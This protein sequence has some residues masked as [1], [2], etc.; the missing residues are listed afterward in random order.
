MFR[1]NQRHHIHA[2]T[3]LNT[4]KFLRVACFVFTSL[5]HSLFLS[6]SA[7]PLLPFLLRFIQT[8]AW[9]CV[10]FACAHRAINDTAFVTGTFCSFTLTDDRSEKKNEKYA[11]QRSQSACFHVSKRIRFS[12]YFLLF[13]FFSCVKKENMKS[14]R[15]TNT[16]I[17]I[18]Q[19]RV[20]EIFEYAVVVILFHKFRHKKT[21][22]FKRIRL[23]F[24]RF[25]LLLFYYL[26]VFLRLLLTFFV[27]DRLTFFPSKKCLKR[28]LRRI[29]CAEWKAWNNRKSEKEEIFP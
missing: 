23:S 10:N 15:N 5:T 12:C 22:F 26:P 2:S 21:K 8:F 16:S 9:K 1:R 6:P 17:G 25:M 7:A 19:A 28:S 29:E 11:K 20:G 27:F 4:S 13:C 14:E 3:Q 18:E 24:S